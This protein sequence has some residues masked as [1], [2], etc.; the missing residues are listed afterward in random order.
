[1]V[2][3]VLPEGLGDE[4]MIN[5]LAAVLMAWFLAI[6]FYAGWIVVREMVRLIRWWRGR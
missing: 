1:M 6:F 2:L 5:L 3:R 4:E